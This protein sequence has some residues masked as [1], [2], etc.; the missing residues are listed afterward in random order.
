MPNMVIK[1]VRSEI[2]HY[3]M[4][5][6]KRITQEILLLGWSKHWKLF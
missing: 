2:R 6:G 4:N 1:M 3:T 5:A